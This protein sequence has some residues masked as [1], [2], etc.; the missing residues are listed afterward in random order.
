M[1]INKQRLHASGPISHTRSRPA[2]HSHARQRATRPVLNGSSSVPVSLPTAVKRGLSLVCNMLHGGGDTAV[3]QEHSNG[4]AAPPPAVPPAY[5]PISTQA[6]H[7]Q[8]GHAFIKVVGTGG[9]G[10]NAIARMISTGLQNVEFWAV[11]TD[12]QALDSNI[13]PNKLQIGIE[14][15]RGLGTG[16]KPSLGEQ[17]AQESVEDISKVVSGA[18]MLFITAGMGGGTGTGAAPVIAR[19]AKDQGILTVG[20]VTYPFS[21]EGRRRAMQAVEGI[22]TLR[23]NVDTL[24][25]IPNDKLLD[26]TNGTNTSLTE[27]FALAD[28]VLRQGV[29]GISDMITIPGLINVD[30][31]DIKAVMRNSGTAMLGVGY[32]VGKDRALQA[33]YGATNAPL[34]QSTIERATGIVYNIT[35]SSNLTLA[36]V[37]SI[38][39]IVTSL[40]DPSC[41]IIFGAVIDDSCDPD[42]IRVTIIATGFSQTFEEQLLTG[43]GEVSAGIRQKQRQ[44]QQQAT[45]A[46]AAE[47]VQQQRSN[48]AGWRP[49]RQSSGRTLL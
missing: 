13:C 16:G 11:N 34:I 28:T 1:Q 22:E 31:A 43:K 4:T 18:D 24:I 30:F 6:A 41:N 23:R 36:E 21:F 2:V 33:A 25:V 44:K 49:S 10:G 12:K 32:G 3:P 19:L 46:T 35:G 14:L 26:A 47:P 37:N 7:N 27:A 9:G 48:G 17:A 8:N 39:E 29:G 42:E 40:A 20:V 38:S 15:T 45:A 5:D